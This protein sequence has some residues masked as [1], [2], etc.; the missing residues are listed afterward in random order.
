MPTR[1]RR[2]SK[3]LLRCELGDSDRTVFCDCGSMCWGLRRVDVEQGLS[4]LPASDPHFVHASVFMRRETRRLRKAGYYASRGRVIGRQTT[5]FEVPGFEGLQSGFSTVGGKAVETTKDG[6][7]TCPY[8]GRVM[9]FREKEEQG[10][11][12]DCYQGDGWR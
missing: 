4:T 5:L 8:C 7:A 10:A 11:C 1:K 6:P 9:T 12:N 3:Q 2:T